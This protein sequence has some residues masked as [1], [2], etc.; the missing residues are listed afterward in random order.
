MNRRPDTPET[1]KIV[2]A[3]EM[4]QARLIQDFIE[5]LIDEKGYRLAVEED[6]R[7]W[8]Q[9]PDR[10]QLM[11]EFFGVDTPGYNREQEALLA[12]IRSQDEP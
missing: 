3:N 6:G 2:H 11:R 8:P 4:G 7:W 5:W 10:E 12:W 1:D 9:Q